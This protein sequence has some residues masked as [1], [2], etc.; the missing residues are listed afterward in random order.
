MCIV[1]ILQ[2]QF[3]HLELSICC[4]S[5]IIFILIAHQEAKNRLGDLSKKQWIYEL[6]NHI[7]HTLNILFIFSR[8]NPLDTAF[9]ITN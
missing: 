3:L 4:T 8:N 7:D 6:T 9:V 2:I 5:P 1:E